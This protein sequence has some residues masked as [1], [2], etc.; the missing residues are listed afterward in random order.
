MTSHGRALPTLLILGLMLG[1]G[2]SAGV[3]RA[4][5]PAAPA[6]TA[7]VGAS[8]TSASVPPG[9]LGLSLEY[10][11]VP[12]YAGNGPGTINPALVQLI[13]NLTPGQS[14]VLRIG[15]RSSDTT[16]W[17]VPHVRTP[18]GIKRSLTPAWMRT[19]RALAAALDARLI[20]GV[21][22]AAG[23]PQVA[24]A[25]ARAL[26]HGIG[27][28]YI[29]A[30]ELGNEPD[31]YAHFPLWRAGHRKPM[32]ARPRGYDMAAVARDFGR[33]RAALPRIP[34]AGPGLANLPWMPQLGRFLNTVRGVGTVTFHRY[35]LKDCFTRPG[36]PSFPTIPHLFAGYASDRLAQGLARYAAVAHAHG[37]PFRVDELNS[38]ACAGAAGVS[39]TFASALWVID[40]LFE[41][42]NVGVDGVNIHTLPSSYYAPFSFT[43]S[44]GVWRATVN[45]LYYGLL[46]FAQA[47]P[48][49]SRL[50]PVQGLTRQVR[51]WATRAPDGRIHTVLI[52]DDPSAPVLVFLRVPR[53]AAAPALEQLQAP[54]EAART[55]VTLGG[56]SFAVAG[57][58]GTLVGPRGLSPIS[59]LGGMYSIRLPPGSAAMLTS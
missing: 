22:L 3:A 58:S 42:A 47:A 43:R 37:L 50:L 12:A 7:T 15:G 38:V 25:E 13:R 26:V 9:F 36:T 24:G 29:Q 8:P 33:W 5:L 19:T 51:I 2:A 16:W 46:M 56:Q 11:A 4:D 28:R 14:P 1:A 27:G 32:Y 39:N 31:L 55:G 45:P 57:D 10:Q 6:V 17:P 59:S 49:G 30:L 21:N 48:P 41:M 44:R 23:N 53:S 35:P 40:V 54:S 18:R 20:L 34:L 52:N